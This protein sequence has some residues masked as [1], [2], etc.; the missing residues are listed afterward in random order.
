MESGV[1][2]LRSDLPL[3]GTASFPTSTGGYAQALQW[4]ERFGAVD[5]V[6]VEFTGAARESQPLPAF[7][8]LVR[9]SQ[10]STACRE[11][12][13]AVS[14]SAHRVSRAR[15]QHARPRTRATRQA[16]RASHHP[17]TRDLHRPRRARSLSSATRLLGADDQRYGLELTHLRTGRIDGHRGRHRACRVTSRPS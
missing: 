4:L 8:G 9:R 5:A 11:A 3:L 16:S 7:Q 13:P 14:G 15:D 2:G 1:N 10:R 17:A 12:R 6:A